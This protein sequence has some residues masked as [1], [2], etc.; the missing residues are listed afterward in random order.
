MVEFIAADAPLGVVRE[1]GAPRLLAPL[2]PRSLRDYLTFKGHMDNALGRLGLAIPKEWFTV[3]GYYKGLPDT[4]I[5]TGAEIPWPHYTDKLDIEMELACII[6]RPG[7]DITADSALSHVFGYTIWNDVSARDVQTRELPL[8]LGPAKAK[9]WDGSNVL[10]PFIVTPDEFDATEMRMEL[11]INGQ[12]WGADSTGSM[13]HGF[14]ELIAYASMAQTLHPGDVLGSGT[15]TGGSGMEQDRWVQP[16][17]S[18]EI[19]LVGI[20]SLTNTIG[21]KGN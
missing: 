1:A 10:G 15:F 4:V 14:A 20:G 18:V 8:G 3:P 11:R 16:G 5:G 2:R 13:H 6:G 17:D 21:Q 7:K 12:L 19:T 9:D